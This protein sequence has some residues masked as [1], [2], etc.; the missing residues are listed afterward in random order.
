MITIKYQQKLT[1]TS[2]SV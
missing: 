2:P 1:L